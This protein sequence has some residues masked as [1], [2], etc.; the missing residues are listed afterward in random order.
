R[1][2]ADTKRDP[3]DGTQKSDAGRLTPKDCIALSA[4]YGLVEIGL[5]AV[6]ALLELLKSGTDR[7]RKLAAFALGE[8][9]GTGTEVRDAL[10]AVLDDADTHI[11]IAGVEAL[12]RI[13]DDAALR[14]L[15]PYLRLSR[16]CPMTTSASIF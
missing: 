7:A 8:I 4:G 1:V 12:S 15:V 11:R 16:W 9:A 6:P 5:P 3:E 14:V 10:I 2:G 13:G